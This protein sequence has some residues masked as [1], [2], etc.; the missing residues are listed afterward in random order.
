MVQL[1]LT[2]EESD[3]LREVIESYLSDL[4]MEIADTDSMDFREGLK[5]RERFLTKL[6]KQL[7]PAP[8]P[9]WPSNTVSDTKGDGHGLP[10]ARR[11]GEGSPDRCPARERGPGSGDPH[12]P[13]GHDLRWLN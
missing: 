7:E 6:L 2:R 8:A 5:Q 3:T 9:D 10:T 1:P 11:R 12:A 13:S 4:R